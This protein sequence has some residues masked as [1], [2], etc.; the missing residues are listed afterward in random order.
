MMNES[1]DAKATFNAKAAFVDRAF[2]IATNT[3]HLPMAN[4]Q[5]NPTANA[6]VGAGSGYFQCRLLGI[7]RC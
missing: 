6:T 3:Y 1:G 7:F 5:V 2:S 4:A